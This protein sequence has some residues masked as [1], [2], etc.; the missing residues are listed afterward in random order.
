[1]LN[2]GVGTQPIGKEMKHKLYVFILLLVAAIFLAAA[3]QVQAVEDWHEKQEMPFEEAELYFELNNTDGD[4]G[5]HSL[6]DG[7]PWKRLTIEDRRG[8][9][10]LN[11]FVQNRLKWQGLTEIFFESAEPTFDELPPKKFFRR[12]PAGEYEIEGV[13]LRNKEMESMVRLTHLL[14]APPENIQINGTPLFE[15][16]DDEPVEIKENGNGLLIEWAPVTTSHPELGI[17][18]RNIFI[19]QYEVV[20]ENEDLGL[21]F[22]VELPPDVTE[23]QIPRAFSDLG[24]EFKLEILAREKSHNQTA[25]ETCFQVDRGDEG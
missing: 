12:F 18:G 1:M 3:G 5:I 25:V 17:T 15:G 4:L 22:S 11:I 7:E 23:I 21:V 13:T 20:L 2:K 14:P 16:C 8:R 24:E 6:I 19:E 9:E 10:M